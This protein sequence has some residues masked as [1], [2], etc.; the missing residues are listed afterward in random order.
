MGSSTSGAYAV[1]TDNTDAGSNFIG[2]GFTLTGPVSDL[3]VGANVDG[4]GS[5][6]AAAFLVS[7]PSAGSPPNVTGGDLIAWLGANAI[8]ATLLN[9]PT[10]ADVAS[11]DIV[12]ATPL[13]AG[14]YAVIFASAGSLNLTDGNNT[15]GTPNVFASLNGDTFSAYGYDTGIRIFEA[16]EPASLTILGLGLAAVG[17]LRRRR[18]V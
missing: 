12:F 1:Y 6:L 10:S 2:A 18:A 11:G 5:G 14:D 7:L 8:G 17:G 9:V 4:F 3:I 13:A 15:I 16:P